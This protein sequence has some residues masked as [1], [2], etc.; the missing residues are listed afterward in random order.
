[1]GGGGGGGYHIQ[2]TRVSI[3][4]QN[5]YPTPACSSSLPTAGRTSARKNS[6]TASQPINA[7]EGKKNG[8]KSEKEIRRSQVTWTFKILDY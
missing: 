4:E 7:R 6:A 3:Q 8:E 5:K 1:M 2:K